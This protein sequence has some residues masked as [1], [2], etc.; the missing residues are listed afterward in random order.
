MACQ[1]SKAQTEGWEFAVVAKMLLKT[2]T[3]PVCQVQNWVTTQSMVLLKAS[4]I[5]TIPRQDSLDWYRQWPREVTF[6]AC[7]VWQFYMEVKTGNSGAW[8]TKAFGF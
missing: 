5:G 6:G 3:V 4:F 1:L 2:P 7:G 8:Q